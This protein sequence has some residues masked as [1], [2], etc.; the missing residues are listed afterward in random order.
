MPRPP[1]ARHLSWFQFSSSALLLSEL[2]TL[3]TAVAPSRTIRD[4][5]ENLRA[6]APIAAEVCHDDDHEND[7]GDG[8]VVAILMV[9]LL[10]LVLVLVLVTGD[11]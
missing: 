2:C 7:D 1:Q 5:S 9:L 8:D 3:H 11:W 6:W 10:V 4:T